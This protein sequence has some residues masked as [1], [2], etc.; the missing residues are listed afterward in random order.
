[1]QAEFTFSS[2]IFHKNTLLV[3][4]FIPVQKQWEL[5]DVQPLADKHLAT[6]ET[7]V[8]DNRFQLKLEGTIIQRLWRRNRGKRAQDTVGASK[9]RRIHRV[10][11]LGI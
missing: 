3:C 5:T 4:S 10:D 7:S 11:V 1:M 6:I 8:A 2:Q 9:D